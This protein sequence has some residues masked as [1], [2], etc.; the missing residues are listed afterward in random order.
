MT[1]PPDAL[2]SGDDLVWLEPGDTYEGRWGFR[3]VAA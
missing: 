2:N 1:A 3:H